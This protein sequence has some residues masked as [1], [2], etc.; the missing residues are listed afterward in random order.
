MKPTA[1]EML[2]F[3][4]VS[5]RAQTPPSDM[6]TTLAKTTMRVEQRVERQVEQ[7]EDQHQRQRDDEEHP[8]LRPPPSPGTRRST[9]CGRAAWISGSTFAWASATALARSRPRTP[10]LTAISRLPCSREIVEAPGRTNVPPRVGAALR[11]RPA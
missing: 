11:R 5:N 9:R 6:A 3:V 8:A 10:N 1:A 4:P 2:K 7:Q